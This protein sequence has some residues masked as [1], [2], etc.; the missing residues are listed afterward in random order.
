VEVDGSSMV[1]EKGCGMGEDALFVSA[2]RNSRKGFGCTA[3]L[4]RYPYR[5]RQLI[6]RGR[7]CRAVPVSWSWAVSEQ[8][9]GNETY[10]Q[11][12]IFLFFFDVLREKYAELISVS[13]NHVYAGH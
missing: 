8:R 3:L 6:G 10:P 7:V 5:S 13:Q 1:W 9:A 4:L 11:N 12:D 2:I